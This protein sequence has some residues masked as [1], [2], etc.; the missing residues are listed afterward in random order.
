MIPG[1]IS[2]TDKLLRS[3]TPIMGTKLKG[4]IQYLWLGGV[5]YLNCLLTTIWKSPLK[6]WSKNGPNIF[7]KYEHPPPP[8]VEFFLPFMKIEYNSIKNNYEPNCWMS[9]HSYTRYGPKC[10]KFGIFLQK[11]GGF[12]VFSHELPY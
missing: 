12:R 10:W 9:I 1:P 5:G 6:L 11:I 8:A 2:H 7:L 4:T 3:H